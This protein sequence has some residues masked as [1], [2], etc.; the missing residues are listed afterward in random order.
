MNQDEIE[1]II[2][3]RIQELRDLE[4]GEHLLRAKTTFQDKRDELEALLI[5]I[6]ALA[7]LRAVR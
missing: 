4:A 5:R 1:T 3:H 6:H 2:Q 7:G